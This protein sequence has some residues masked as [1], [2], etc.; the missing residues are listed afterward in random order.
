MTEIYKLIPK[1]YSSQVCLIIYKSSEDMLK[2]L[3]IRL[4][5]RN[6]LPQMKNEKVFK[7]GLILYTKCFIAY[8]NN[9]QLIMNSINVKENEIEAK[10]K[11]E[12]NTSLFNFLSVGFI[13]YINQI[14]EYFKL[15]QEV[16]SLLNDYHLK[17]NSS[18]ESL[19]TGIDNGKLIP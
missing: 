7:N 5:E 16:I 6:N 18:M 12:M 1:E 17:M 8:L 2:N 13:D 15:R 11:L 9:F 14:D 19:I 3:I 4:E 10:L